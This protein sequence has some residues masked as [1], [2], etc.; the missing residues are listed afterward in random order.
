M[1]IKCEYCGNYFSDKEEVCPF[2]NAPNDGIIRTGSGVPTTIEG[3]KEYVKKHG[4]P[5]ENLRFFIGEDYKEP[6][7]F[8]IYKD[9]E[10]GEFVVYKNK[11]D[12]SRAVRY[13]GKDEAYAVNEIYQKLK[14]EISNYKS[15]ENDKK[16]KSSSQ[17]PGSNTSAQGSSGGKKPNKFVEKIITI[18][19]IIC[20]LLFLTRGCA[21]YRVVPNIFNVFSSG[22]STDYEDSGNSWS[23]WDD[24]DDDDDGWSWGSD[25]DSSWD[26]DW[27]SD[28]D[29]GWDSD[30]GGSDWDSDW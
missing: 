2:C 8:G 5:A 23:F 30:W 22:Y 6:K 28:W 27:D 25:S 1:Q 10:L 11:S 29:S 16:I 14:E 3:L 24:D 15:F 20:V 17:A 12:G 26:S 18:A 7:A 19:I 13:Q 21:C 4:I 9:E